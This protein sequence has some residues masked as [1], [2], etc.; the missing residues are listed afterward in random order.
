MINKI[1]T[2]LR[3]LRLDGFFELTN[4]I[5]VKFKIPFYLNNVQK[6]HLLNFIKKCK[7]YNSGIELIRVG[8]N[9]D[10]G[11]LVPNILNQIDYCYSP[12]VGDSTKFEDDLLAKFN[13][14]S[15]T[16]DGTIKTSPNKHQFL[17]KNIG[18]ENNEH[19]TTLEDWI[20]NNT[21]NNQNLML[22]MDIEG[23]EFETLL[24]T[25]K[26]IL[27]LFKI[28]IVE[29]HDFAD[30]RTKLGLR[31]YN[32]LF[33]KIL[34]THTICHIHPN[35]MQG[36]V[37]IKGIYVPKLME[38]TFIKNTLIK[39]KTDLEYELPHRLDFKNYKANPEI[40]LDKKFY[41]Y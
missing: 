9:E 17:S 33:T 39:N 20:R 6:S 25:K 4:Y 11:Y 28:M 24:S 32:A 2:A 21:N 29:F 1:I 15:F 23:C 30:I 7:I 10:G 22:Q 3:I 12:G 36:Q 8:S 35:N 37:Y 19:C 27:E 18:L 16:A 26:E 13:I 31:L 38:I 40:I 5:F 34:T 41:N 14:Q